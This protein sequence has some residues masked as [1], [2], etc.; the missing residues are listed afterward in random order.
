MATTVIQ[1][2]CIAGALAGLMAGRFQGSFTAADYADQVDAAAAIADEF[3]VQNTASGAA[4]ADADNANIGAVVQGAAFA[5]SFQTGAVS[6][7]PDDYVKV[8]KQIY[9]AS[10]Q[11]LASLV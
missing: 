8:G 4:L 9:A 2:S 7:D 6:D 1:N 3:L 10:K 11:A 5:A